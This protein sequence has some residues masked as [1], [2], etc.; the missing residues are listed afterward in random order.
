M[1]EPLTNAFADTQWATMA[2][3]PAAGGASGSAS[4]SVKYEGE[5]GEAYQDYELDTRTLISREERKYKFGYT[6]QQ[7][8]QIALESCKQGS[9]SHSIITKLRAAFDQY[10]EPVKHGY[11]P[12]AVFPSSVLMI[13]EQQ[14]PP[15]HP[16]DR[17]LDE[18][19]SRLLHKVQQQAEYI[20]R[21]VYPST[22]HLYHV[23]WRLPGAAPA[24]AAGAAAA[25]QQQVE[26]EQVEQIRLQ[27]QQG[28]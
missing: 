20:S 5:Q 2:A 8:M 27:Q 1:F 10:Y 23:P 4:S 13:I 7:Q 16:I 12:A 11:Y 3:I 15:N 24:V 6:A 9:Q 19:M 17:L 25:A 18:E 22:A 21:A 14:H 26:Q 28:A